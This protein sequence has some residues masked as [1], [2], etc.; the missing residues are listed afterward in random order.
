MQDTID[1][2]TISAT[3]VNNVGIQNGTMFLV[4]IDPFL[5][6]LFCCIGVVKAWSSIAGLYASPEQVRQV[7]LIVGGGVRIVVQ[8]WQLPLHLDIEL[9]A[10]TSI[11]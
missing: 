2:S 6:Y 8:W 3:N 9:R 1:V 7:E 5:H 4:E 11:P 10:R